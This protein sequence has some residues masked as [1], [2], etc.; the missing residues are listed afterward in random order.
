[1]ILLSLIRLVPQSTDLLISINIPLHNQGST[2]T[3]TKD[4]LV[5]FQQGR[6]G[7]L[8]QQE[9]IALRDEVVGSLQVR[10]WSLFDDDY[11]A[12]GC[13]DGSGRESGTV[14]DEGAE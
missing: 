9:G 5:D 7:S 14:N 3:G 8:V 10:D 11:G 13:G 12:G 4:E 6:Y 2:T 1:M